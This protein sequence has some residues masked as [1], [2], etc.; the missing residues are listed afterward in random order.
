MIFFSFYLLFFHWIFILRSTWVWA[1]LMFIYLVLFLFKC[2]KYLILKSFRK[3]FLLLSLI[4]GKVLDNG[5]NGLN[6]IR[7]AVEF[8]I[9]V[10]LPFYYISF[11]LL[12]LTL[13]FRSFGWLCLG[14]VKINIIVII[15]FFSTFLRTFRKRDLEFISALLDLYWLAEI[16]ILIYSKLWGL[17]FDI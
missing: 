17:G 4:Q 2:S 11:H 15:E 8:R 6:L 12:V 14:F 13:L 1:W 10:A 5:G 3:L 9:F 7:E 16:S